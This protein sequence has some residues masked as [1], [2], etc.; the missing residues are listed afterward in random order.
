MS[1]L[2]W[3]YNQHSG[4]PTQ[5]PARFAHRL[6]HQLPHTRIAY[7][8][9]PAN[10]DVRASGVAVSKTGM[11]GFVHRG[12]ESLPLRLLR[13]RRLPGQEPP[14]FDGREPG[15][16]GIYAAPTSPQLSLACTGCYRVPELRGWCVFSA[17]GDR[18]SAVSA[19]WEL[20][21]HAR[22]HVHFATRRSAITRDSMDR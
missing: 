5:R 6:P 20:V 7:R 4:A 15:G 10:G 3:A 16:T 12:F 9:I 19:N 18:R 17:W 21:D 13:D 1:P 11:G 22:Q 2:R 14:S 8:Q